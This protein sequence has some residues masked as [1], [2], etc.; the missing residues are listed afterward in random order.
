MGKKNVFK[1]SDQPLKLIKPF[2]KRIPWVTLVKQAT[3]QHFEVARIIQSET[4]P[5]TFG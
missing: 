1:E 5:D 4:V 3:V 2:E